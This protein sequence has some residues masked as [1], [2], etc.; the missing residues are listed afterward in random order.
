MEEDTIK[1]ILVG[2]NQDKITGFIVE[3]EDGQ[4]ESIS[5]TDNDSN[6][7]K[8]HFTSELLKALFN[9]KHK[10]KI[11]FVNKFG[12]E[13]RQM[14]IQFQ[15]QELNIEA[16]EMSSTYKYESPIFL[17][18]S[19]L[20]SF[21]SGSVTMNILGYGWNILTNFICYK[22]LK[23]KM[24]KKDF[25]KKI[26]RSFYKLMLV[27]NFSLMI[28]NVK[29]KEFNE[30]NQ[31]QIEK[32]IEDLEKGINNPFSRND[33]LTNKEKVNL[34][35]EAINKNPKLEKQDKEIIASLKSYLEDNTYLKYEE[36]YKNFMSLDILYLDETKQKY[37]DKINK[38]IITEASY[39]KG[40]NQII[41]YNYQKE[42]ETDHKTEITHEVMH[43]TGSFPYK[44]VSINE[45]MTE[46][47]TCEYCNGG[48]PQ[49]YN[50]NV[51]ITRLM[52]EIIGKDRMLKSYSEQNWKIITDALKEVNPSD[53]DYEMLLS[54]LEKNYYYL[55]TTS[56]KEKQK[57]YNAF[58]PYLCHDN[59]D[60]EKKLYNYVYDIWDVHNHLDNDAN[61]DITIYYNTDDKPIV[62]TKK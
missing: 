8:Q 36:L 17:L 34:L 62:F 30:A 53:Y 57:I 31:S 38:F 27:L 60:N 20:L 35:I 47:L 15:E 28:N 11:R 29:L 1:Q 41:D 52:I 33:S 12:E 43:M 9:E 44:Y 3:F 58:Y 56:E 32:E 37:D 21:I 61:M 18:F 10:N 2:V 49:S 7:S 42:T 13:Y 50:G 22:E 51:M 25:S 24:F 23:D 45:G 48:I 54:V 5:I 19:T 55:W 39:I 4:L 59:K 26:Y 46:L 40:K 6:K 14:E 16:Q